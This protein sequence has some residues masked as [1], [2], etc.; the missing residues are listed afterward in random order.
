V[1]NSSPTGVNRLERLV[2]IEEKHLIQ[3]KDSSL[4][5]PN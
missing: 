2:L 1:L 4:P 3:E 5:S